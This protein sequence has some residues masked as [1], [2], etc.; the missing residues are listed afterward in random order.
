MKKR[1]STLMILILLC[2]AWAIPGFAAKSPL[3]MDEANLLSASEEGVLL[4]RLNGL[5]ENILLLSRLEHQELT[6]DR[7]CFSLDE[8]LRES[9]LLTEPIW[10][11][12]GIALTVDLEDCTFY[13]N[14][15]LLAQV[16][17]N[18]F[19]NAVKFTPEGGMIS[20]SLEQTPEEVVIRFADNGPGMT[21]EEQMLLLLAGDCEEDRSTALLTLALYM[22]M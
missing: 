14:R 12:K 2:V 11:K 6:L 22:I 8:Q 19:G 20:V 13:G 16:W 4:T 17:Q 5:S 3:L 10:S 7:E 21:E 1:I 15:E 9:I 18:V